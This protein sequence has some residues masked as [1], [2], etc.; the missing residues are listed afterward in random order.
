MVNYCT[1]F[2]V[3]RSVLAEC[4][5]NSPVIMHKVSKVALQVGNPC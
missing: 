5:E 1:I 2:G 3:E 4:Y